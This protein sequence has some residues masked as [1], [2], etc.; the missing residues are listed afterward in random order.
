M[1]GY[2]QNL[3]ENTWE[4]KAN[5]HKQWQ[6]QKPPTITSAYLLIGDVKCV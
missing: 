1:L 4:I 6:Q 2:N 5:K 3:T